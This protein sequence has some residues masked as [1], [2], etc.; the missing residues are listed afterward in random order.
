MPLTT[1][2]DEVLLA[3]QQQ[4]CSLGWY[5]TGYFTPI[6]ADY[7][8]SKQVIKVTTPSS[9]VQSR[10]FYQSFLHEVQIEGWGRTMD[11]DY[12]GLVTNDRQWHSASKPIGSTDEPL[13]E[14]SVAVDP[15]IIKMGQKLTIPTLPKP[16]STIT[17][18]AADVGPDIKGKHIDVYTGEGKDA[19]LETRRITGYNNQL[20]LI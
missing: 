9:L 8:G 2:S 6:E 14:H 12:I 13:L 11:G 20:C 5:I 18:T 10:A 15:N 16:W 1:R 7:N 4:K 17:L 19:G 3:A